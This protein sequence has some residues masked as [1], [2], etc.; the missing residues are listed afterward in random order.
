MSDE[1]DSKWMKLRGDGAS[2]PLK[3]EQLQ[4]LKSEFEQ[5]CKDAG[6]SVNDRREAAERTRFCVWD[7][8]HP[9]G[10]KHKGPDGRDPFPFEGASD[11]RY[12][13][14]DGIGLEQVIIIMAAL[15]RARRNF[16][17][18]EGTDAETAALV[19]EL[20]SWV[21][22]NQL[23]AEW[24][25]EWTKVVQWRQNDSPGLALMQVLWRQEYGLRPVTVVAADVLQRVQDEFTA[26]QL[27]LQD[28]D[29]VDLQDLLAN[30]ARKDEL[31]GLLQGLWPDLREDRAGKAAAELQAEG[32]TTFP[33]PE[34]CENRLAFKA[35]RPFHDIFLPENT[36]NDEQRARV[37]FVGEWFNKTEL[38]EMDA[39]GDFKPGSLAKI[40]E[41]EGECAWQHFS[42]YDDSGS[43]N[44]DPTK[45]T[46]D[47]AQHRGQYYLVTAFFRATGA[48][49]I[50]GTY[51]VQFHHAVEESLTDAQLLDYRL[52]GKRFPFRATQREILNDKLWD[53]RGVAE[54]SAT[55]Q[56]ALKSAHDMFM[57]NASLGA[58]PPLEVPLSR[59]RLGL[60][61]EP[62]AKIKVNR[63]GE[64]GW[65]APPPFPQATA[66]VEEKILRRV[67]EYFGLMHKEAVP[68][69]VRLYQEALVN[70]LL[71]DAK[72]VV[73]MGVQLLEQ[74][75]PD[76]EIL[77]AV[78]PA[79][80]KLID[81]RDAGRDSLKSQWVADV[82]VTFEA[83][84]LSF[85]YLKVVGEMIT[86]YVLKWDNM[87]V[88]QRDKLVRWFF[89]AI[90]PSLAREL[91]VPV[92]VART[93]EIEEEQSAF[94]QIANGVEPP[95]KEGVNYTL[96][97]ETLL[98]IGRK[99]PESWARLT[100]VSRAILSARIAYYQ[101]QMLQEQNAVIGATMQ[102][103]ALDESGQAAAEL[104][105]AGAPAGA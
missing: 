59:P 30:P 28:S 5:L 102:Q 38:E 50:P 8:Q 13:L 52:R 62:L 18:A 6:A 29:L 89:S 66:Q 31:A 98:G 14:A 10:R 74:Y 67:N 34:L 68:D 69:K 90:S 15:M 103:P 33:Y 55:E 22:A 41:H 19:D 48:D 1:I 44:E 79:G 72:E 42:H 40:L 95:M 56:Q 26:R 92:D 45:R 65:M 7:N 11:T 16:R 12:R 37:I 51:T 23:G 77:R 54:L 96:R 87:N 32:E 99:N 105:A 17:P 4:D 76:E 93:K 88:T 53:T 63:R 47:K 24:F 27:P 73:R 39:R 60:A 100:P 84:L 86:N 82:D 75:M 43:Y 21:L 70:F 9:D 97:L 64:I 3:P 35:R 57:D 101:N 20:W 25:V 78:G 58:V 49:G 104:A 71:V 91:T 85:E 46:W 80:Q 81:L 94:S 36:P 2:Q 83:G 61:I